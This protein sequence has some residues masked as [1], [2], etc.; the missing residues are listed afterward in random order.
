MYKNSSPSQG[1]FI[2]VPDV[3]QNLDDFRKEVAAPYFKEIFKVGFRCLNER[4]LFLVLTS[5][6]MA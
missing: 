5:R 2:A 6:A 4:I 3:N 1:S